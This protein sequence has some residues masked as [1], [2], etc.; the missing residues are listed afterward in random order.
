MLLGVAILKGGNANSP[1]GVRMSKHLTMSELGDGLPE[2]LRS[3]GSDEQAPE[4]GA[5]SFMAIQRT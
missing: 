1:E 3:P 2:M 5:F 4:A